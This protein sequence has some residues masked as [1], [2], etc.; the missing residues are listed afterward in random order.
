MDFSFPTPSKFHKLQTNKLY[1]NLFYYTNTYETTLP[2]NAGL[3]Q[4]LK[5]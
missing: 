2:L 1:T 3:R 5:A 4:A